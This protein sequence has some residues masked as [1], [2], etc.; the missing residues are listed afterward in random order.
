MVANSGYTLGLV[1]FSCRIARCAWSRHNGPDVDIIALLKGYAA[2]EP[3]LSEAMGDNFARGHKQ[4][5][6]GI[7]PTEQ[8]EQLWAVMMHSTQ[9]DGDEGG[10]PRKKRKREHTQSNTLEGWV[11]RG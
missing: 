6:G 1:N 2:R 4:A 11:K 8:F 10:S 5:S 9:E 3:G 7:V